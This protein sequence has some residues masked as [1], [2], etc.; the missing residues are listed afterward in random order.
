MKRLSILVTVLFLGTTLALIF[1]GAHFFEHFV[2]VLVWI[3]GD[4]S[5]AYMTPWGEWCMNWLGRVVAPGQ[6]ASRQAILG[7][8]MLHLI[9]NAIF[10]AGI[11]GLFAL[12]KKSKALVWAAVIQGFHLY[13]HVSLTIS[14]IAIGKSIG[15]STFFGLSVDKL[16]L[17]GYRVWWHF[18]FNLIPSILIVMVLYGMRKNNSRDKA[19]LV[20]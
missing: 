15:F 5:R 12:I 4:R 3:V 19:N 7:F 6:E 17:V 2:Q 10:L 20:Q 13:E 14:A 8:E 9:G 18:I 1:Q 11:F 16:T